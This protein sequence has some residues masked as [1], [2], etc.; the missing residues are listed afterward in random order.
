MWFR[1][2]VRDLA[3]KQVFVTGAASGIG[4]AVARYAADRGA[5]VHLT[6]IQP[7]ALAAVADEIRAAGGRVGTAEVADIADHAQVRRLAALVTERA[8]A[9]D[10]V[11]N[12]AGIAI[13]GTVRSLE[14]EHW[15]RLV[16]VNLMGPIHVIEELLPPMIDARRG[17]QLVNISSAAGII[18]MPWH[19]AYSA[20]KFGLRGVSEVLRYD[21]RKHR[22]GVSLVCPGGVDTGLVETIRIA[23][24][25]QQSK[26]F[27]RA[28]G[29]FQKRAVSPEQAA[30]AIWRGALR[31]RYWVYTSPDIRLVHW[32]QRYFPPGYAIAMRVFNYGA[33]RVLPAVEQARRTDAA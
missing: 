5:V 21:L 1:A 10:V 4:R 26:A 11:L 27:V 24:I 13:W 30:E 17:G 28:R 14:P 3:G 16:D 2:P 32:L 12:V 9:M 18:A 22:I 29:H 8:G 20:T 7:E 33:N 23:G 6:D 31:N 19:A 25:D 15:Q